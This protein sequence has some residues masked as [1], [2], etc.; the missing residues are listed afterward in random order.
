MVFDQML[1]QA[2]SGAVTLPAD[3]GQGRAIFGGVIGAIALQAMRQQLADE[4]PLRS[5]SIS[6]IGP[7]Q[8]EQPVTV[9]AEVLRQGKS[10]T[11]AEAR[12][13]QDGEVR[14]VALGSFG[15]GRESSVAVPA[16]EA[17]EA[18]AP[19]D[20]R[21]LPMIEGVTPAFIRHTPMRFGLGGFP[22]TGHQ[23]RTMGGWMRF[24]EPPASVR[25]EHLVGLIDAWP[26]A[27]LPH[28]KKP[29]PASSLAW[30]MELMQPAPPIAPDD[31]LL[32]EAVVEQ[33]ADGYAQTRAGVW[34]AAGE[35]VA[36]SRQTVTVFG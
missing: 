18:P 19:E 25:E 3:W 36:L 6:F 17:P 30:T 21:E 22:F 32:Y 9:T 26:P 29:A 5:L 2:R 4:R 11:Q 27:V 1:E 23:G 31:W 28:L 20:C 35:L 33:A 7:V 15:H 24:A 34:T 14:L 12:L 10:V 8:A 16:I 13:H